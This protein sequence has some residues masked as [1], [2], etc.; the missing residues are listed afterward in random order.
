V[1][2]YSIRP[3]TCVPE[4]DQDHYCVSDLLSLSFP[5]QPALYPTYMSSTAGWGLQ[6]LGDYEL[7]LGFELPDY[8]SWEDHFLRNIIPLQLC[9]L[10]IDSLTESTL[11]PPRTKIKLDGRVESSE[12]SSSLSVKSLLPSFHGMCGT[13]WIPIPSPE[14]HPSYVQDDQN[15]CR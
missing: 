11:E 9:Q 4:P 6:E 14:C 2:K 1:I 15:I 5:R 12:L 13:G 3:K 10:V 7:A 8:V